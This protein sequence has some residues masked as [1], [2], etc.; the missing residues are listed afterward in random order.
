MSLC[1]TG[2]HTL[3]KI[4]E[5]KSRQRESSSKANFTNYRAFIFRYMFANRWMACNSVHEFD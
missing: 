5:F 2:A 4:T 3:W 1:L